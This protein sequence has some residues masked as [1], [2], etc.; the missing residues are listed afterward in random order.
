[1]EKLKDVDKF[2]LLASKLKCMDSVVNLNCSGQRIYKSD[3][4]M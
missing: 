3:R 4:A 1:M 2:V